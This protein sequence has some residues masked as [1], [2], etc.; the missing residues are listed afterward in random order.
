VQWE[1]PAAVSNLEGVGAGAR[2]QSD[3]RHRRVVGVH[4]QRR[5]SIIRLGKKRGRRTRV[6]KALG[7][8]RRPAPGVGVQR[9]RGFVGLFDEGWRMGVDEPLNH[10]ERRV[11][12]SKVQR[13]PP[14]VVLG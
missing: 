14:A 11:L 7:H 1:P 2:Q 5:G 12:G 8:I 9:E 4:V 6:H 10:L 13:G 3:H